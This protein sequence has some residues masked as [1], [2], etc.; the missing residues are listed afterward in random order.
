V[1][2]VTGSPIDTIALPELPFCATL[3]WLAAVQ[4]AGG[5][6]GCEGACG[7]RHKATSGRCDQRQGLAGVTLHLAED[8]KVYCP[9]CFAPI[10]R[11]AK[12]AAAA[13]AE[14]AN[15]QRYAQDDLLALLGDQ[16]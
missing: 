10:D 11:A 16:A 5:L 6:C 7:K 12:Q 14:R 13:T 3:A 15:A 1:V 9:R 2:S 4:A 8:G